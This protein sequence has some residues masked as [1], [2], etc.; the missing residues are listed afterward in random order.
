MPV[1]RRH[2][3]GEA[4]DAEA[5]SLLGQGDDQHASHPAALL[6][7]DD[8]QG[9]IG[10]V[11]F[12]GGSDEPRLADRLFGTEGHQRDMVD[13]VSVGEAL[14]LRAEKRGTVERNRR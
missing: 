8:G 13:A 12:G 2:V 3:E 4:P 10:G 11:R 5:L 9:Q 14:E 6:V 1:L 7:V